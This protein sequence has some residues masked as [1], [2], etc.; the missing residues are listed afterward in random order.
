MDDEM[1]V[2]C[3]FCGQ[4]NVIALDWGGASHQEYEEDCQ[5][6]CRA[7]LVRATLSPSGHAEVSVERLEE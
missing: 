3:P 5:V 6:C 7:W 2:V 4:E 1:T